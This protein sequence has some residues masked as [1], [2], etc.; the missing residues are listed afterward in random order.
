QPAVVAGGGGLRQG[1]P[2]TRV[3]GRVLAGHQVALLRGGKRRVPGV[4]PDGELDD[5][6]A[7]EDQRGRQDGE[8]DRARAAVALDGQARST[9]NAPEN[10]CCREPASPPA[11]YH[12]RLRSP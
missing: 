7:G 2:A 11:P 6:Q 9:E 10:A 3:G 4:E 12:C 5:E 1:L 8:L